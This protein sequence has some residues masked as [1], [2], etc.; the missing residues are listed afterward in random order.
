MLE[1]MIAD[2]VLVLAVV[3]SEYGEAK[4]ASNNHQH[5]ESQQPRPPRPKCLLAQYVAQ[6]FSPGG[7]KGRG[8]S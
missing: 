4:E 3:Q 8:A 6:P 5:L 1:E 2:L 7:L